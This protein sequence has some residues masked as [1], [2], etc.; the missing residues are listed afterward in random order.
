MKC[1]RKS[2][3]FSTFAD[4]TYADLSNTFRSNKKN[5]PKMLRFRGVGWKIETDYVS[6][7]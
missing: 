3:L 5:S 2:S 4:G 7:K 1:A 6:V